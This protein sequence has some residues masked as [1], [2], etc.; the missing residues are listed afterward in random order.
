MTAK[1][2]RIKILLVLLVIGIISINTN[3]FLIQNNNS[4]NTLNSKKE[5]E[6]DINILP[7]NMDE[8]QTGL[9]S[10]KI[11]N[12]HGGYSA[13]NISHFDILEN[14]QSILGTRNLLAIPDNYY[15]LSI[16]EN[17]TIELLNLSINSYHKEQIIEDSV[18][19]E[20]PLSSPWLPYS[21]YT[22]E[23]EIY[24]EWLESPLYPDYVDIFL[25]APSLE[26]NEKAF[27]KGD[28]AF[29]GQYIDDLNPDHLDI[30]KGKIFQEK[31]QDK[32]NHSFYIDPEYNTDYDNPYGG[33]FRSGD[34]VQLKYKDDGYLRTEI[35][36]GIGVF[37]GNPS[38]AW[39]YY[40]NIP[41]EVNSAQLTLSWAI[42][43]ASR[44]E[45]DD[46]YRV[47]ARI[48]N[49]Y[50]DGEKDFIKGDAVPIR[51]AK[52]A[53]LVYNNSDFL[54]HDI[55]TRTYNI[56]RLI[57]GLVGINKFDFGV[58]AKNPSLGEEDDIE[59]EFYSIEI[60]FNTSTKY[61]VGSLEFDY[62]AVDVLGNLAFNQRLMDLEDPNGIINN[63]S[64]FFYFGDIYSNNSE[65][66][67]VLPFNNLSIA[68]NN[69]VPS[70]HVNY[71]LSQ[72]Y[73]PLLKNNNLEIALGVGFETNYSDEI[74][75]D[76]LL[77]N[78]TF[79]INYK[80]LDVNYSQ[81]EMSIDNK[82][83]EY[84]NTNLKIIN[85]TGWFG[86][87][88]HSFQFRTQNETFSNNTYL[89]VKSHLLLNFS[90]YIPNGASTLYY[91]NSSNDDFGFWNI[92][93]NNTFSYSK[94][95]FLNDTLYFNLSDYSI[96]YL[97]L[98]AFDMKGSSSENW[99]I[100]SAI[101][102]EF[103]N[104]SE[105][106]ERFNY[107]AN[108]FNQS[109]KI[110]R[111]FGIGNWTIIARQINYISECKFNATG[112]YSY[113]TKNIPIYYRGSTM[114]FNFSLHKDK[115]NNYNGYFNVSLLDENG[116]VL[117]GYPN[118][119]TSNNRYLQGTIDISENYK[120]GKYYI[121]IKWNDTEY[122]PERTLRFGSKIEIF[123]VYNA[124]NAGFIQTST[125]VKPGHVA[126]FT[127]YYRTN[128]SNWGINTSNLL[129]YY[130]KSN[131]WGLWGIAWTGRYQVNF[132]YI[133]EGNY[134]LKLSTEGAPNRAY[135]LSFV[136][137]KAYHQKQNISSILSIQSVLVLKVKIINGATKI[138][139]N[140]IIN[141][142]NI[143]YVN[144][145][146]NSVIQLNLTDG[147]DNP[148]TGG[149]I[150]GKI[151]EYGVFSEAIDLYEKV[152]LPENQGIY[153]LTIDTTGLNAT[154]LGKNETL[155]IYCFKT[156]Y[157]SIEINVTIEIHKIP[158]R[159]NLEDIE[160]VYAESDISIL[161]TM[162]NYITPKNPKP[163]NHGLLSYY[164]FEGTALKKTGTLNLLTNGVYKSDI[165]LSGLSPGLYSIYVNSAANN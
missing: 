111:A 146:I 66:V 99:K 162:R 36:P 69:N 70:I 18:F 11:L 78:V 60:S 64:I 106:I 81:L 22:G 34:Y 33:L 42:D 14:A 1:R 21:L 143:P 149:I 67:R 138:G 56:T 127:L 28:F 49:K 116:T 57:D 150:T 92:T 95:L 137:R 27:N 47:C 105:N 144:D 148:L 132:T 80:H 65:M 124:T 109:V 2:N 126:N 45:E 86:G 52:N 87:E 35:I 130:N 165:L 117:S 152:P 48:N 112:Y 38:A 158:T 120:V 118:Y 76:I 8:S 24:Q 31:E 50:I 20:P 100:L 73:I 10:D 43:E 119:Y 154:E 97:N 62:K 30:A 83:W 121:S 123:L 40:I 77:D 82:S 107:T 115:Y 93:Y 134:S 140:Y 113:F 88:N 74:A 54:D 84:L 61:E 104:I 58:W 16:P 19:E 102:P 12:N 160:D 128:Y 71:S 51:G 75:L 101:S 85:T 3:I 147:G 159:L 110:H 29:W 55:I 37:R 23:G 5:S 7:E 17:W 26:D 164:I 153:N 9:D 53:L 89:N 141:N 114:F 98:P 151:G 103:T 44:F 90:R 155:Y 135:K 63:A 41:Y 68:D 122:T 131:G 163:N 72:E 125:T 59:A 145:T 136:F 32:Y 91:I 4:L 15:N 157:P 108:L 96:S 46:D 139:K 94:L 133:G 25:H 142:N 161:T 129:V 39:W 79:T 13:N 156:G 6:S